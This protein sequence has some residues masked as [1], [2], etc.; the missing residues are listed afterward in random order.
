MGGEE[1]GVF[2]FG[3]RG[4]PVSV[5]R[6][7]TRRTGLAIRACVHPFSPRVPHPRPLGQTLLSLS[8]LCAIA[9]GGPT[10]DSRCA[11]LD[12]HLDLVVKQTVLLPINAED[13][14]QQH[15]PPMTPSQ[16]IS[17]LTGS[18]SPPNPTPLPHTS[19]N[20]GTAI[21]SPTHN[22]VAN[23]LNGRSVCRRIIARHRRSRAASTLRVSA[24]DCRRLQRE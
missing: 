8:K 23:P 16:L 3:V 4:P 6:R 12:D 22:Y 9:D 1:T 13:G 10:A 15:Q 11:E 21:M 2:A 14:E 7:P 5:I 20:P 19:H 24:G 18:H 17:A